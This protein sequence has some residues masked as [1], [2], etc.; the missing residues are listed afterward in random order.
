MRYSVAAVQY[1]PTMGD[2]DRNIQRLSDLIR[3][4]AGAGAHLV[5]CPEM[6]T[7][8][9]RF[10]SLA[11]IA[12]L[13]E[14]VPGG[15][16]TA[17]FASLSKELG[18]HLV[19]GLPEVDTATGR[20]YNTSV[21]LGPD[22][23]VG[24]YRKVHLFED[25]AV[26]ASEGDQGFSVFETPLGRIA[27]VICMD[28]VFMES[29]RVVSL[30]GAD[31]IAA[32]V[33]WSASPVMWWARALEN[34]TY[35]VC[36]NRWGEE[37]GATYSGRSAVISPQGQTLCS[38]DRGDGIAHAEVDTD[39]VRQHRTLAL[40]RRSPNRYPYA[41]TS[42]HLATANST[43]TRK[44]RVAAGQGRTAAEM[45]EQIVR[46]ASVPDATN[47]NLDLMVFPL[48]D[49]SGAAEEI[50]L[51]AEA[52]S[53]I[54]CHVVWGSVDEN[55]ERDAWVLWPDGRVHRHSASAAPAPTQVFE[56]AWGRLGLALVEDLLDP[57][58]T[59]SL[60]FSGA[61]VIAVPAD[62]PAEAPRWLWAVRWMENETPVVVANQH[63]GSRIWHS[64]RPRPEA[65][66]SSDSVITAEVVVGGAREGFNYLRPMWYKVLTHL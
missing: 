62:W 45:A 20:R 55:G 2:K 44:I 38:L 10:H 18:V 26:W 47:P 43:H 7:T 25:D 53:R 57:E 37:R 35:L 59:R 60:T 34:G 1:E 6:G 36:A 65:G 66:L 23:V 40:A 27:M 5:V 14:R 4:A 31:I 61:D 64:E 3:E 12:P 52:A 13:V 32:P 49:R 28:L 17:H 30:A 9:Y 19:I 50:H 51:L 29:C 15:P 22:G 21:L 63:G 58:A 48:C 39:L 24:K 46:A 56:L 8:G 33:N 16:T 41:V 42:G 54:G 11:E